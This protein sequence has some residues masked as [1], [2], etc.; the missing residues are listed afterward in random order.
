MIIPQMNLRQATACQ[1]FWYG[2]PNNWI[3]MLGNPFSMSN[4]SYKPIAESVSACEA[5]D[6]ADLSP[7][8]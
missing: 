1:G 4:Q 5:Q 8:H 3:K 2:D 6:I 7:A